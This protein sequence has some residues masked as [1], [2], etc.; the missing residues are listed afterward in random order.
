M[1]KKKHRISVNLD[2]DMFN[3]VNENKGRHS[4]STFINI[5]LE[6]YFKQ[7]NIDLSEYQDKQ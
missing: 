7:N 4:I 5:L 2:L 1:E 3:Y 6:E